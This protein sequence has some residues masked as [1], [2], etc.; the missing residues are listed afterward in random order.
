[1]SPVAHDPS[2]AREAAL[3]WCLRVADGP[4]SLAEQTE[5]EAWLSV[6]RRHAAL[7]DQAVTLWQGVGDQ[8][9]DPDMIVLRG[10]AL[11]SVRRASSGQWVRAPRLPILAVAAALMA[12]IALGV[13]SY[14]A[15]RV[16][17]TGIGERRVVALSDGSRLSLDADTAVQVR[18]RRERRD[19]VLQRGRAKFLVAKDPMRPFA[20]AAGGQVVVAVGTQFS[21]ER[22]GTE[23]RVVLFEGKVAVLADRAGEGRLTPVRVGPTAAPADQVLK[24][25][26]ELVLTGTHAAAQLM[27]ADLGRSQA[28]EGGQLIFTDEPL[29]QAVERVNR[30]AEQPIVVADGAAGRVLINGVFTA[31]DTQAFVEGVT[32]AFPIQARAD[33]GR[34]L[35]S[36]EQKTAR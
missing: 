11:E 4:L 12:A 25:G 6:D 3:A 24:P 2:D 20:V 22:V 34:T 35:L 16:Y 27:V 10:A 26:G 15:P 31:G 21:V 18:Y 32:E 5:F 30:Y 8:A 19:L 33:D 36:Y 13:W 17:E 9:S 1:M 29:A 28:W 23:V 14:N 7:Y